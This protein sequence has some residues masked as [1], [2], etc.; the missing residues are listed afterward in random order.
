MYG[1][2]PVPFVPISIPATRL[3]PVPFA[4]ISI[5]AT[6]PKPRRFKARAVPLRAP[7]IFAMSGRVEARTLHR[8]EH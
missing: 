6:R 7:P 4:L 3:K 1:L 2:K 5:P 8:N